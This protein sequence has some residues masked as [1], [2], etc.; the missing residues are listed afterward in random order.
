MVLKMLLLKLTLPNMAKKF[1]EVTQALAP[2]LPVPRVPKF[3]SLVEIIALVV[4]ERKF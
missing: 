2:R 1:L 3:L 4:T